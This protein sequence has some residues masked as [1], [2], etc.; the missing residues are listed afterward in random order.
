MIELLAIH[1]ANKYKGQFN[2]AVNPTYNLFQK[3]NRSQ[4]NHL[5]AQVQFYNP[6]S[7]Q[8]KFCNNST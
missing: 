4:M 1:T 7:C 3:E 2:Y 8:M 6:D 5:I